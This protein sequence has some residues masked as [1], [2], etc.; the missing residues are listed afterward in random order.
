[1][2]S[3]FHLNRIKEFEQDAEDIHEFDTTSCH[4]PPIEQFF[5]DDSIFLEELFK[6]DLMRHTTILKYVEDVCVDD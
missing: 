5:D 3:S 2:H 1:V 6:D 4:L